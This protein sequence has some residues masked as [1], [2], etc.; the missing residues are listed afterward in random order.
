MT[1]PLHK[2]RSTD[3]WIS[4]KKAAGLLERSVRWVQ[5]NRSRFDYRRPGSRNLEFE[6]S[7]V[8]KVWNELEAQKEV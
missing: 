8:L 1:A 2:I 4:S 5:M 3:V 6:L 7:S